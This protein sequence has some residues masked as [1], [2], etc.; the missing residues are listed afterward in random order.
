MKFT[1]PLPVSLPKEC[2]K[3]TKIL[4]SFVDGRND[5]LDGLI[6]RQILEQAHGFAIFT[7]VKAGFLFSARAGSGIVISRLHDGSELRLTSHPQ[8]YTPNS[9]PLPPPSTAWSAPSAIGT[10]GMGVGGQAGAEMTDFLIVLNT[11]AAV[12]SFMSAGS[13]TLGGNMSLAVGPIGRNGGA[14]VALNTKGKVA[15]MYS[16]SRTKGLF[17]GISV[18]G[19]IIVERQDANAIA[20]DADVTSKQLLSGVVPT[21]PWAQTLVR[22]LER[23]TGLPTGQTWIQEDR[24]GSDVSGGYHFG[25]VGASSSQSSPRGGIMDRTKRMSG[26]FSPP[27]SKKNKSTS[28]FPDPDDELANEAPSAAVRSPFA[29]PADHRRSTSVSSKPVDRLDGFDTHFESDFDYSR[30]AEPTRP[31]RDLPRKSIEDY[32]TR[33]RQNASPYSALSNVSP[34]QTQFADISAQQR[35][36]LSKS[37]SPKSNGTG[38]SFFS[39]NKDNAE[40][41]SL[42]NGRPSSTY[43]G[44]GGWSARFTKK[45]ADR[46]S[47][48]LMTGDDDEDPF[49][50]LHDSPTKA[51]NGNGNGLAGGSFDSGNGGPWSSGVATNG[52][53][54]SNN[55][56]FHPGLVE[57]D[58]NTANKDANVWEDDPFG[59][60]PARQPTPKIFTKPGLRDPQTEGVARAIALFDFIAQESGDLSFNKGDIIT[61]MKKTNS[62]DDWWTGKLNGKQGIFPAN[63]TEVV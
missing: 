31:S 15:A 2:D 4:L 6:P 37:F 20:Y 61:V 36:A 53:G 34:T 55:R 16:Y 44:I 22:A 18:E 12:K 23:C 46:K 11:R 8:A 57:T 48:D 25:G 42:S 49:N 52:H 51:I 5:G 54:S 30:A 39:R 1:S 43:G 40:N 45:E 38:G 19:S 21:P 28:Y 62:T 58:L 26:V 3:A 41:G 47:F 14:D 33:M 27:W 59:Q 7:V 17:G 60:K 24:T 32:E 13:L 10:A 56:G 50:S 29:S 63:F 35:L 9:N